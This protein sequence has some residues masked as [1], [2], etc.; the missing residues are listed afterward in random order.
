MGDNSINHSVHTEDEGFVY[1]SLA[2]LNVKTVMNAQKNSMMNSKL[3]LKNK[4]KER[5]IAIKLKNNNITKVRP[6]LT[7]DNAVSLHPVYDGIPEIKEEDI[8]LHNIH[9]SKFK[10]NTETTLLKNRE[11][12]GL[13]FYSKIDKKNDTDTQDQSDNIGQLRLTNNSNTNQL[14]QG[15]TKDDSISNILEFNKIGKFK[16]TSKNRIKSSVSE[17][18]VTEKH[19]FD[20]VDV[21]G[22]P[23]SRKY[24]NNA[25]ATKGLVHVSDAQK[26]MLEVYEA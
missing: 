7:Q 23:S 3:H 16:P 10:K 17:N 13:E 8:D 21:Q 1:A 14:T 24:S 4:M 6:T 9:Y 15:T 5:E 11:I 12:C 26:N 18:L 2:D 20:L 19:R 22:N 25:K